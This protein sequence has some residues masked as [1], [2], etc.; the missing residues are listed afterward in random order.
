MEYKKEKLSLAKALRLAHI[1]PPRV[2]FVGA[3]GKTTAMFKIARGLAPCII[4]TTTHLGVWQA[5]LANQHI[6]IRK[7]EDVNQLETIAFSGIILVTGQKK[8]ERFTSLPAKSLAW[9]NDFANYHS[10]PLLI[11][12]DGARQKSLKAPKE[13][14][15]LIPDFIDTVITVAGMSGIGKPLNDEAVYNAK[16]FAT[17]GIMKEGEKI[18]PE[19]LARVLTHKEGGLKKVPVNARKIAL[20]SQSNTLE[21]QAIGGKIAKNLL[22]Q[23]DAVIVTPSQHSNIQTFKPENL[24]TFEQP[25]AIILAGGK[26]SRFGESKQ[27]LDFYGKT[28]IRTVAEK[29]IQAKLSPVV[30]VT[31]AEHKKIKAVLQGLDV[32]IVP[33]PDWEEGQSSSIRAGVNALPANTGSAI[34]LLSDQP[35]VTSTIMRALVEEHNQTLHPVIAP[36]VEDRRANPVLFDRVTFPA[37]LQLTGDIGGRGIFSKFSP[38]YILWLDSALLLDVDSP[39]D[40]ESLL[41]FTAKDGV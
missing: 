24:Q 6:I 19:N 36:M 16:G 9:L 39:E 35:Q 23:F 31:G 8:G 28:F 22:T 11:E 20:L 12:A 33:N 32:K 14:E 13:N 4:T 3:G 17:L 40:Y 26:S 41:N 30:V 5:K 10:L 34:F 27:L 18:T 1:P 37:L 15:P 38:S 21:L 29:A 2:A 25:S 7:E